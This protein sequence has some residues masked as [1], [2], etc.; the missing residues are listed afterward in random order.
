MFREFRYGPN[1]EETMA[2][3]TKIFG[4]VGPQTYSDG[5]DAAPR[6]DRSGAQVVTE[7][8]GRY[9]EAANRGG[10]FTAHAIVTAPVIYT[11]AAGT[12]GPLLYNGTSD[13]KAVL[14]AIGWGVSTVT[15]AAAILGLTGGPTTAPGS[16]TA[17][18]SVRNCYL[19]GS[20]PSCSAYRIG[21][22]SAAGNFCGPLGDLHT[23]ALTTETGGMHW[24]ETAGMFVVPPGFF[25]SFA[26]SA[27]ASTTVANL[28]MIWQEL[29][30]AG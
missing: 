16:I 12:G 27:T 13:K 5:L 22:P 25:I 6:L 1:G 7:V 17:V 20:L 26:A 18:D 9:Y 29:P 3:Q 15:T 8:N 21:T 24:I 14:L 30:L 23:A 2:G 4:A 11:T 28:G 19:G 10:V